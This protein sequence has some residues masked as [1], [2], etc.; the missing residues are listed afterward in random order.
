MNLIG[1]WE[2]HGLLTWK[3]TVRKI[4]RRIRRLRKMREEVFAWDEVVNVVCFY[5]LASRGPDRRPGIM[6]R[7]RF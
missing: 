5:L 4:S 1:G 6:A 2:G 7:A 3:Q